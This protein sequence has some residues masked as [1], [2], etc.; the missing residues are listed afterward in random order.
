[1]KKRTFL[2]IIMSVLL[3][4]ACGNSN[5][6]SIAM[7][8]TAGN[9][10][11]ATQ[12][13]NGAY[14][15]SYDDY[16]YASDE[17]Y[18]EEGTAEVNTAGAANNSPEPTA[19]LQKEM[20]VYSCN[21]TIDVLDF[22]TAV[23]SFKS[24]LEIYGGFIENENYSDGGSTGRWYYEDSE[25]WQSYTGTV[26]VPCSNYDEFCDHAAELGYL[27]SKN[28]SVQNLTTEYYDLNATL[29]IYEAK[30]QRYIALLA[31][32]T[33]DQYAVAVEK[34]LTDIQI[35]ISKLKT[36]MNTIKTDVAYSYVYITINEVKEYQA[37]PVKTDTFLD[38]LKS[39][40]SDSAESFLDFLE[41]FLFVLIYLAPYLV[42]AAIIV[43]A[44]IGIRKKTRKNKPPKQPT[45]V[46]PAS[47]DYSSVP[48]EQPSPDQPNDTPENK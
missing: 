47:Y 25:K 1:M 4:T 23:D 6:D 34:E 48:K 20:L 45:P 33:D 38:R 10:K 39:T 32:I 16:D 31:E 14:D 13:V 26:R 27:R 12:G 3:L 2:P 9:Y 37:E 44:V 43:L 28:A 36:R 11:S 21:M 15:Y 41:G 29:E 19:Q 35:E 30:E 42:I 7:A 46:T 18:S 24:S 17:A 22:K 40:L 8:D 5:S